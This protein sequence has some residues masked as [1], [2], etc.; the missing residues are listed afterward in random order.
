MQI[1]YGMSSMLNISCPFHTPSIINTVWKKPGS[2]NMQVKKAFRFE[3]MPK[4]SHIRSM[5]QFCGCA[6]FVF[7]KALAY[8]KE[9]YE[10]DKTSK[11]SYTRLANFLPAW[12]KEFPWLKDCHS[13]VLQQSLKDLESAYRNFFAKRTDFPRFKRKGVR[14]SFRYPQGIKL[15]EQNSRIYL[16]KLGWIRYR[17]SQN[18]AGTIKNVTVS[19]RVGKWYVSIQTEQETVNPLP[20]GQT[21]VGIDLGI[22]RFATLS[23]GSYYEPSNS[24]R[25]HQ[26][27]L[28]K[29]QQA[30]SRKQKFSSNWQ[31]AK[32]RVQKIHSRIADIRKDYL[33]KISTAISKSHA[34]VCIEDLQVRNMSK[35]ASGTKETPGRNVKAKSGLNK[36]ILDQGWYEFRRQLEYKLAW[37]GGILVA[38]PPQNTSRTCPECGYVS[39]ENRQTQ[40]EF[41]CLACGFEENA[42]LVGA[43]NILRAGH[44][45]L[46]C[47]VNGAVMPSAAGTHR[48]NQSTRA[49]AQ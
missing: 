19:Q 48:R 28:R 16:P 47:E 46:A 5:K 24:F 1:E 4:G 21:A 23:D 43:I 9:L 2:A 15:E 8:Q 18:I 44:A 20:T 32:T 31:K 6:R 36:S 34:M 22:A 17:K 11:F 7:N 13:Q 45:Q 49:L 10:A 42:D 26:E 40:A 3:L 38:V 29:T 33:H 30:M 35:S 37:N 41:R 14:D 39:A 27:A 25:H 12:K